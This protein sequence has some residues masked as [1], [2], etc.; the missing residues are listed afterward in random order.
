[1]TAVVHACRNRRLGYVITSERET[2]MTPNSTEV[3][4]NEEMHGAMRNG[5]NLGAVMNF[6]DISGENVVSLI[7]KAGWYI[8]FRRSSETLSC[9][10]LQ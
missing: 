9:V 2:N 8:E 6:E 10:M 1:M 7:S 5:W 3:A 4:R